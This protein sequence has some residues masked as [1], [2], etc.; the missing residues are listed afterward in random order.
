MSSTLPQEITPSTTELAIDGMTC[1]SCAARVTS[2]L[3]RVEGVRSARVNLATEMAVV[4][5]LPNVGLADLTR[6]VTDAGYEARAAAPDPAA[7]EDADAREREAALRRRRRMLTLGIALA[8][9]TMLLGMASPP[10]EGKDWLMFALT[11]PVWGVVGWE[12]HRSAIAGLRHLS[13]NMDTL[14]SLGSTAA[15]AYSVAATVLMLP[16]YYETA[17][18]IIVLISIGKYLEIVMRAKSNTAIRGLLHLRPQRA[19]VVDAGGNTRPVSIDELRVGDIAIVRAGERIPVDGVIVAGESAVDA[20]MVTGESMPATVRPGSTV[21]G[22]TLNG[23]GLLQVRATVVGSGTMLARIVKAVR[24]AQ[25]SQAP[26]QRLA[27]RVAGIFVPVILIVAVLTFVGWS[28]T[29]HPLTQALMV[30]VAVIVVACPCAMGLA[31]PTAVMAGVAIAARQG[32][33]FKNA[34]AMEAAGRATDVIFDKTGTLT[35]GHPAVTEIIPAPGHTEREILEVAAAAEA[36]STHPIAHAIV[37]LARDRGIPALPATDA[38]TVRGRGASAL[39]D[40][41]RALTGSTQFL[42]EA[43]VDVS[44][45]DGRAGVYVALGGRVIGG[46]S[47]ADPVRPQSAQ[48]VND[49][50]ALGVAVALVSGDAADPVNSVADALGIV[51]RRGR[52]LPEDKRD[53]V[54]SLE[55]EGRKTIFVGDGI[56]DAPA[57]AQADVGMAMGG[58]TDIA[59]ESADAA[60]LSDDPRVVA[61]AIAISRKTLRTI[62][63]N[64]AWAFV[65]NIILVPLAAFGFVHPIL[66]AGAMGASSLF[67]VGNSL[68]LGRAKPS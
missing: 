34:E 20:S 7:E 39:I 10:F 35:L 54:R 27:D 57:L 64:L 3:R 28:L 43:G 25:G 58:G 1:A 68:L 55:N 11:L 36:S 26:A 40:G 18:A 52:M 21:I 48:A 53:F 38:K 30:A 22:G 23:D 51:D 60:I 63:Q 4:E 47:I 32:I 15:L 13:A 67:V 17:S 9:P 65:Y 41:R 42:K 14:V 5:H 56:N 33:L 31:T 61:L 29:H 49:L 59:I 46:I 50:S 66:A 6:A 44:S 16:S 62:R 2:A 45:I 24:D 37:G 19:E 12:F 8:V